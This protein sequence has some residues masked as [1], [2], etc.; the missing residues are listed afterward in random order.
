MQG[1]PAVMLEKMQKAFNTIDADH[2]GKISKEEIQA[3]C[4]KRKFDWKE[5]DYTAAFKDLDPAS[6]T[7]T[8]AQLGKIKSRQL[9]LLFLFMMIDTNEDGQLSFAEVKDAL[10]ILPMLGAT[11][12]D[13]QLRMF[14]DMIDT[15]KDGT[16]S[17]QEALQ[18]VKHVAPGL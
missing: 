5:E 17:F 12:S 2:D 6:Q 8:L 10:P 1:I 4:I 11:P 15:N 16:L 18:F 14:F 3:I 13:A 7:L 9:G